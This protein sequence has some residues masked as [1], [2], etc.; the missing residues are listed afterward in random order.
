MRLSSRSVGNRRPAGHFRIARIRRSGLALVLVVQSESLEGRSGRLS[1]TAFVGMRHSPCLRPEPQSAS[2][3]R[4]A[5]CRSSPAEQDWTAVGCSGVA[6]VVQSTHAAGRV[7][8]CRHAWR[9]RTLDTASEVDRLCVLVWWPVLEQGWLWR[10]RSPPQRPVT[11]ISSPPRIRGFR[12]E[13]S[14]GGRDVPLRGRGSVRRPSRSVVS[15]ALTAEGS[16]WECRLKR[17]TRRFVRSRAVS[18]VRDRAGPSEKRNHLGD[19][20]G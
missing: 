12:A 11:E 8:G 15:E 9:N 18:V 19:A 5:T 3:L 16:R 7:P 17:T 1:A 2:V 6:V 13:P 20:A 10:S 4:L 14:P